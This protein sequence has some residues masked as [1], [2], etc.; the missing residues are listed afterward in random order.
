M[1]NTEDIIQAQTE[2]RQQIL[3]NII[4]STAMKKLIVAGPGT[5]KTYTFKKILEHNE[6][7]NNL[8]LT[9]IR[10]LSHD[11]EADIG[12]FAEV[13]TFHAYCKKILHQRN[14]RVD[15]APYLSVLISKD[16]EILNRDLDD[17][18]TKFQMLDEHSREVQ[19]YLERGNYYE[20]VSFN[21]SVYR[22]YIELREQNDIVPDY[23]LILIDEYQ[24]FN[25]LE[26]A[27]LKE[28]ERKGS[29]LIV[30]DD[31]QAIYEDR[32]ASPEYLRLLY[33]FGDYTK[34]ELPFCSRCPK[35]IVDATNSIIDNACSNGNFEDRIPKRFESFL[36]GEEI[37]NERYPKIFIGHC[38]T[39][40][41][42][43]R[44][45]KQ[46]ITHIDPEEIR[47]SKEENYP[48]VLIIGAKQYLSN[49][50]KE[51][52][53]DYPHISYAK[54]SET[55]YNIVDGYNQLL[56]S[57]DS[58][59]G[60]RILSEF[61]FNQDQ[62][63]VYLQKTLIGENYINI[64]PDS[65]INTHKRIVEIINVIKMGKDFNIDLKTELRSL[66]SR[67][68]DQIIDYYTPKES[69]DTPEIDED[70]PTILLTSFKGCKGLSGCHVFIVGCNDGY[71]PRDPSNILDIEVSQF[72]VALTRTRKQCHMLS[73]KW[74]YDPKAQNFQPYRRSRLLSYISDEFLNDL[75]EINADRLRTG[76]DF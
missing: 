75:G 2:E 26:V 62:C 34:F 18:D 57:L 49:I 21:D 33:N 58:N 55:G 15:L 6:S 30:G 61:N 29:I 52:I 5:E 63:R 40:A 17:F 16:T 37:E 25:P 4:N 13:K 7:T 46:S 35:V 76:I 74:L 20:V 72:I 10:K 53:D 32:C 71:L 8:V 28:M 24:D 42:V 41:M 50:H 19:F 67:D 68:A 23:N 48:T 36:A 64:L 38:T 27:F 3:D 47:E 65:F 31:D 43:T 66:T 39:A 9:F 22:L 56:R 60:W 1:P 73:N 70:V 44:Y 59:L 45:I 51:L 11:L 54:P 69:V 14:A 12:E